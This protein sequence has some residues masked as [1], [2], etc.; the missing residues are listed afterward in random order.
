MELP[1]ERWITLPN[2]ESI[3]GFEVES[4]PKPN[5]FTVQEF[6]NR[7]LPRVSVVDYAVNAGD[8]CYLTANDEVRAATDTSLVVG[9]SR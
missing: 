4:P 6:F 9:Y 1:R 3:F 2:G 5:D 8:L 7:V